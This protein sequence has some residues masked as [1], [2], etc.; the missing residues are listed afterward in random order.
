MRIGIFAVALMGFCASAIAQEVHVPSVTTASPGGYANPLKL[1][2]DRYTDENGE[3]QPARARAPFGRCNWE[4]L[5]EEAGAELL[6]IYWKAAKA[7]DHHRGYQALEEQCG[8]TNAIQLQRR[9]K[10]EGDPAG[11]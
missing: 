9:Y 5:T 3:V 1:D 6:A 2:T 8:A 7:K 11:N 4:P 10:R